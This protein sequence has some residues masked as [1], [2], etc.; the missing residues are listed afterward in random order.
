MRHLVVISCKIP[1]M[2]DV[3]LWNQNTLGVKIPGWKS[4]WLGWPPKATALCQHPVLPACH[5]NSNALLRT[6]QEMGIISIASVF[7]SQFSK[8][9][10]SHSYTSIRATLLIYDSSFSNARRDFEIFWVMPSSTYLKSRGE[11]E[12]MMMEVEK[13]GLTA[14]AASPV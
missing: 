8:A 1:W 7:Q 14:A 6:L 9:C 2:L 13:I 4:H 10:V 3:T 5:R 12:E 11:N